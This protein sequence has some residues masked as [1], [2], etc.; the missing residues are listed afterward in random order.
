LLFSILVQLVIMIAVARVM[1]LLF[2]RFGQP[3]VIGETVAGLLLGPSLFGHFFSDFSAQIFGAKP[4][5]PI[6]IL[7]QIG[8]I[9]LMFQIGT[10]FEFGHM[11]EARAKRGVAPVAIASI[12]VPLALGVWLGFL[13]APSYASGIPPLVY[14]LFCGV[15]LAITAVPVLGR[16]LAEYGLNRQEL[17]VIAIAAAAIN[18]VVG[19][20][21]LACVSAIATATFTPSHTAFQVGGVVVFALVCFVA[22]RPAAHWLLARY[23][24]RNGEVPPTLMA[25]LLAFIFVMGMCTFHLGIFAIFGGFA[26]GLLFHHDAEFVEAWRKQVGVFVLVF[27]LPIFF[28]FTGLRTNVLGLTSASDLWWLL[29]FVAAAILGK[30]VPV[31]LA[32][33]V[34]GYNGKEAL[35]I[36]SLMN[37]R[38]LMELI[39]LN[40]GF[41]TGFIPQKIFTM[42]VIMAVVTTLMAGPFLKLLMPRLGL[43]I[44]RNVEA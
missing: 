21:L 34:S 41:E 32:A 11:R 13:S 5:P 2:R 22:L 43:T 20:L 25:I 40:I 39:V 37:T 28:T 23:P 17:G 10:N 18:D 27:F 31:F 35:L 16:I 33:R 9:F 30:I 42:L 29:I 15:A 6:V 19:W 8:L 14:A 1:N 12:G 36:G 44:P 4:A 3:G 7:S 26:A 24:I 38:G